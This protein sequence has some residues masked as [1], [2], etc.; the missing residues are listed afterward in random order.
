M[1]SFAESAPGVTFYQI[2]ISQKGR[3][4]GG[5]VDLNASILPQP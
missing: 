5:G 1:E 4:G 2:W 3:E